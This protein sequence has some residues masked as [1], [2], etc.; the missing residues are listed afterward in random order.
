MK[1]TVDKSVDSLLDYTSF[2]PRLSKLY[3]TDEEKISRL[4][5]ENSHLLEEL[6]LERKNRYD[7]EQKNERLIAEISELR[8]SRKRR[9]KAELEA[10]PREDYSEYKSDG[11]R[12]SRPADPIRSYEDF[13]EIQ[14]YFLERKKI[15]DWMM[16]TVGVS[17]GLRVSDLLSLKINQ[18]LTDDRKFRKRITVI[19]Q[20][21][22]KANNCLITESVIDAVTKYFD[23]INWKFDSEDYLF[24]SNKTKG[25]MYEEYGWKILSDAGKAL[26]LPIVTPRS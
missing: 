24:K 25:K 2:I 9:T 18:I 6:A 1:Q 11:K 8:H 10:A 19:E 23:S 26:S 12:K 17:L 15:R 13:V 7:A 5:F 3:E 16:W 4:E 22:S 20:K 14:N 21:T